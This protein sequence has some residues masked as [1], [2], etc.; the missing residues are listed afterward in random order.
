MT[1]ARL[2][3]VLTEMRAVFAAAPDAVTDLA[4]AVHAA[5]RVLIYGVGR[6]GLAL[7]G[8]AMRL[9][10][11]GLDAHFVGQLSAP[12][13][14]GGDLVLVAAALGRLPTADAV[15]A[16]ARAAGARTLVVTARPDIVGDADAVIRLPAQTM[17]DPPRSALPLG[18]AFELALWLLCDLAAVELMQ[19]LGQTDADLAARHANLL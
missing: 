7:Q 16:T 2:E 19:R 9:A 15:L 13:V 10:H 6:N 12:P 11:L 5:R 18:S 8:F 3:A 1:P 14:A 17:A 4:A